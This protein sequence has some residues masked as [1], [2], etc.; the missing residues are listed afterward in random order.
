MLP[1]FKQD[2]AETTEFRWQTIK[3]IKNYCFR[4]IDEFNK[5][6]GKDA[7]QVF[8]D[9]RTAPEGSW[10][11]ADDG[12]VVQLLKVSRKLKHPRDTANYSYADGWCRTVVGTFFMKSGEAS[13]FPMDTDWSRHASRYTFSGTDANLDNSGMNRRDHLTPGERKFVFAILFSDIVDVYHIYSKIFTN[14]SPERVK[15]NCNNLMKQDRIMAEI[16]KG[17]AEAAKNQGLTHEWVFKKLKSF[18]DEAETDSDRI[19]A[20]VKIGDALNT[21]QKSQ[22]QP[23][24]PGAMA[25]FGEVT[26]DTVEQI[27]NRPNLEIVNVNGDDYEPVKLEESESEVEVKEEKSNEIN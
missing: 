3:G 13:R 22:T 20:T 26:K 18:A 27:S 2:I 4:N 16:E 8:T 7:P 24:L 25:L 9:W 6:F 17:V 11:I 21:F 5:F 14:T 12:G 15:K 1:A 19:R 23:R 10:I